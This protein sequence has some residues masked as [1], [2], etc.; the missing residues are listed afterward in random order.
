MSSA[1]AP[2]QASAPANDSFPPQI[3]YI[4]SNEA[5]ERFSFYGMRSI[6]TLYIAKHLGQGASK[7]SEIVHL[8]VFGVYFM[9][10]FGAWLSD[11]VL[12]RYRTIL[13]I[14]LFYCLGHGVLALADLVQGQ[15]QKLWLLYAGLALISIGGG[16]IK[17]C[18]SAFV[19]DQF[20]ADQGHLLR[21]AYGLFYW[22]INFGSFFSFL[23]IPRIAKDHG[24]GW[25]FG[26]PGIFMGLATL[27]FWLGR[28]HYRQVPPAGPQGTSFWEMLWHALTHPASRRPGAGF[29]GACEHRYSR[30][31]VA[32]A[33]AAT[34]V[35]GVFALI[36]FFWA[37]YDQ[38]STTWVLQ[39]ERMI[40][41]VFSQGVLDLP[42]L[43]AMLRFIIGKEIGAEQMQSM[44]ALMVM[45]LVPLFTYLLFP[46]TEKS[47]L[48][49]T[50]LRRM[51]AGLFL[52]AI[53][54]VMVAVIEQRVAGGQKLSVLWQTLPYIV[55]TAGEVLV[56]NTGLEFAFRE[57]PASM[58]ST[59]MSF[60]L[61]TVA[62]GNLAISKVFGLNVKERL[63]DGTEVLHVSGVAFFN[64]C[65]VMLA[66]VA[67]G[68][69][70]VARRYR[71]RE[72]SGTP[73]GSADH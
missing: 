44:N 69:V 11:R 49:V 16:G 6:L 31:Q 72:D 68:F 30:E 12:G 18:V 4:I 47:G 37:L 32:A 52:T 62:V 65:A 1:P 8:F 26:V 54:F 33:K 22:S 15:Q 19:G 21:R 24:Y 10:L 42:V 41:Y 58:R 43:G 71:Y 2:T 34:R 38:N 9:P 50:T 28:K 61:L 63:P 53:S 70:F 7:A 40:P 48:Q 29:W 23:V 51:G 13:Y 60:W 67:I 56:S 64:L 36:P 14:S 5:F 20:H 45:I 55:L 27:V 39:G 3:K 25:A 66:V 57:A 46:V 59:M 73:S 17:P 35:A